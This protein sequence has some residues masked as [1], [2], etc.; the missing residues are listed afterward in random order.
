MVHLRYPPYSKIP[1][2]DDR[3]EL[4]L[5]CIRNAVNWGS[6]PLDGYL[7]GILLNNLIDAAGGDPGWYLN[8][9]AN[10]DQADY[11]EQW[12]ACVA[13]SKHPE[14]GCYEAWALS[15]ISDI[16]LDTAYYTVEEVRHYIRMALDSIA[17]QYP[18]RS[19]E[20]QEVIA[21]YGL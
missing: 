6:T 4:L 17:A 14:L 21:R 8:L 16:E 18:E 15:D 19:R 5:Y 7:K 13:Q 10:R 2:I 1:E 9:V 12:A 3:L 11:Q 20:V